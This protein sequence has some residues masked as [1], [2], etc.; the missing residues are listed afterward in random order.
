MSVTKPNKTT[1]TKLKRIASLSRGDSKLEFKWLMPHFNE[2][3]LKECFRQING[4]R[5]VGADGV[6][7]KEYGRSVDEKIKS[8]VDRM[9]TMSYRPQPVREVLIPKHDSKGGTR[10]LGISNFEDKLIQMMASKVLNSIYDPI[11]HE[12]SYGFRSGRSCH[13]AIK[14]LSDDLHNNWCEGLLMWI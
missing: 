9:K 11:F 10:P 8:L 6:T 1:A 5:S 4:R 13:D 2:G 7:K 12:C 3:S 14:A